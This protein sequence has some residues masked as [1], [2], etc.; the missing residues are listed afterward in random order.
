MKR[1]LISVIAV[2]VCL[3]VVGA[4]NS[5]AQDIHGR[6][7]IDHDYRPS[8][9]LTRTGWLSDYYSGLLGTPGDSRV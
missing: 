3:S 6:Y 1:L 7:L 5:T 4:Q 9:S 8:A 2:L